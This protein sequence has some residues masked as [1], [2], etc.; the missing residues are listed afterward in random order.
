MIDVWC[1]SMLFF[2][3]K[4]AYELRISDWS[5]DVCSSDLSKTMQSS[6]GT[7]YLM[8]SV[9]QAGR[10]MPLY[11]PDG[12]Y[13]RFRMQQNT[14]QLL[15]EGGFDQDRSN[16]FEG[17]ASLTWT[18]L[19]GLNVKGLIG[20]NLDLDRGTLFG[21]AYYKYHPGMPPERFG[22]VNQPNR[23]IGKSKCRERVCQ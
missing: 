17:R 13:A 8:Q 22:W 21:R 23:K 12:T 2:K 9:L 11:N 3:Q 18:A 15:K 4:T 20:Y 19:P 6:N 10:S 5:S 7:G 16:R 1:F 14:M